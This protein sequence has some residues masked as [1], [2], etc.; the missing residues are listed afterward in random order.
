MKRNTFVAI[1][2]LVVLALLTIANFS[3]FARGYFLHLIPMIVMVWV[4]QKGTS[5]DRLPLR[6]FMI[7]LLLAE[8]VGAF[9]EVYFNV[10][11]RTPFDENGIITLFSV[12]T[13]FA[14]A[15]YSFIIYRE[16]K[17]ERKFSFSDRCNIWLIM[18]IGFVFLAVDDF[19]CLHEGLDKDIHYM[20]GVRPTRITTHLDDLLIGLYGIIGIAVLVRFGREIMEFKKFIRYLTVGFVFLFISVLFDLAS[21]GPEFFN[22]LLS[23]SPWVHLVYEVAGGVEELSK[24][25][26]EIF[27]LTGFCSVLSEQD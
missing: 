13:L 6:Q 7:S 3:Y 15:L 26:S 18:A 9:L 1:A 23:G 20:L 27:F 8:G 14:I 4:T 12:T 24:V 19:A 5:A 17:G 10:Y 11:K 21:N 2:L 16:R 22:W 25:A